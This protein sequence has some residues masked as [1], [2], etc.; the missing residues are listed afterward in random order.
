MTGQVLELHLYPVVRGPATTVTEAQAMP[1]VGLQGDQRRSEKRQ[2]TVL[3]LESWQRALDEVGDEL[4]A[5]ARRANVVVS[6]V[7]LP[8]SVG[9]RL[10]IGEVELLIHGE[11]KP[12]DQ[13]DAA[14]HGL[15]EALIP[16]LRGGVHGSIEVG[17]TVRVG[18][19]VTL[20]E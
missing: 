6:G 14:R 4:P 1:G 20:V 18:D 5:C 10:R 8:A 11:T 3:S 2:V 17:G 15:R 13:M 12:C 19:A 16:E 9:R 7:D